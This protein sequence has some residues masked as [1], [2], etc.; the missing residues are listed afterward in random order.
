MQIVLT[1]Q[2]IV[3]SECEAIV[4]AANEGLWMGGGVC[5]VIFRAAG[6]TDL[7]K[8]C[9]VIGHCDTGN[10]VITPGFNLNAKYIIH[11]VGPIYKGDESITL[12][13]GAYYNSLRVADE[14][15]IK[16]IAFPAISTG[17]FGY[18]IEKAATIALSTIDNYF[19]DNPKSGI[20]I[21][22][23]DLFGAE[24]RSAFDRNAK[25]SVIRKWS[26]NN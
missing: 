4:N 15:N 13:A 20:N 6:P 7:T 22:E 9:K 23:F 5:G 24:S 26:K 11:A 10:A 16:S 14:N 25:P 8:A 12:L 21:V 17:I 2:S 3:D 19:S 1:Q 18:P